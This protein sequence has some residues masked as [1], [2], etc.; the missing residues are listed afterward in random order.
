MSNDS[1]ME[2][3]LNDSLGSTEL[4]EEQQEDFSSFSKQELV[5]FI[6]K[7]SLKE[8]LSKSNATLAQLKTAFDMISEHEKTE[9]LQKYI[10]DGGEE[11]GF[12]YKKDEL[13]GKFDKIYNE[14]RSKISEHFNNLEK[15]KQ[16][17]LEIKNSLLERLRVLISGEESSSSLEEF[18]KIQDEWKK[19]GNV[20]AASNQ[21]LWS[22]YKALVDIFYNNRSIFFELKEL[23]RKKNL[24][25]KRE[26]CD[27]VEKLAQ[28]PSVNQALKE[29]K[30]LHEEFRLLGPVPKEEQETLWNR[31]KEASDKIYERRK[32]YQEELKKK[33]EENFLTK[34]AILEKVKEFSEF[35]SSRIDEWK[36]KSAELL[37]IQEEWKKTGGVLPEKAKEISDKFWDA[38][39]AYYKKKNI[40]FKE[41]DA[42]R[43]E[44]MKLKEAL[45]ERVETIKDSEEYE[46]VAREIRDLQKKWEKIGQV[47]FKQKDI[48]YNRFKQACDYFFNKKRELQAEAE[49]SFV[50]N[51]HKKNELVEKIEEI[52]KGAEAKGVELLKQFQQEW[53]NIGFVPKEAKKQIT[54]RYNDALNKLIEVS[55]E[56]DASVKKNIRLSLD[57]LSMKASDDGLQALKKKEQTIVKKIAGIKSEIDR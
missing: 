46:N 17:N 1:T 14:I 2:N 30:T 3:E 41:L 57:V 24:E 21:D 12:E 43:E 13:S 34:T 16:K 18:K 22:N 35:G 29:L 10:L 33:A 51:L 37:K 49:K 9:A 26:I 25:A 27:K 36:I 32:E 48:I 45:C 6:E 54:D 7:F 56:I 38:C 44:N 15:S 31:L 50:E 39:K 11:N 28:L 47:P 20:P 23:D 19:T 8:N 42:K 55:S 52:A 53:D 4:V 5:S 40:F